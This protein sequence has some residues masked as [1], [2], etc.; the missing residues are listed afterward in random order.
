MP[1]RC[2]PGSWSLLLVFFS[3]GPV[4]C[5]FD[6]QEAVSDDAGVHLAVDLAQA[7]PTCHSD[8]PV[9]ALFQPHVSKQIKSIGG[10]A[11][12]M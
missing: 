10:S 2:I 4:F 7:L 3:F 1:G 11:V 8:V 5:R 12:Y 6:S 9:F